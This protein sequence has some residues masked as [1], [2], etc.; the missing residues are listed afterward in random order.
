MFP[1]EALFNWPGRLRI[2]ILL[3]DWLVPECN[4][5]LSRSIIL[6]SFVSRGRAN[7]KAIERLKDMLVMV[8][9][10]NKKKKN[11]GRK[12]NEE[13]KFTF[14]FKVTLCGVHS[15]CVVLICP[16]SSS[17]KR[18][19]VKQHATILRQQRH[20]LRV[21]STAPHARGKTSSSS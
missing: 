3:S 13:K 11:P 16:Q 21:C 8:S 20:K 5:L 17:D 19:L 15:S 7:R 18:F 6:T 14:S 10:S 9:Y 12:Q 2:K 4:F 1:C